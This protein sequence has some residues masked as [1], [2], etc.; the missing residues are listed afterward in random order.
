MFTVSCLRTCE[1]FSIILPV[2][3]ASNSK[4]T[5]VSPPFAVIFGLLL[6]AL[7]VRLTWLTALAVFVNSN[8]SLP[9]ESCNTPPPDKPEILGAFIVGV[10]TVG[11]VSVLFVRVLVLESNTTLPLAFGSTIW[12]SPVGSTTCKVVSCAFAVVPSNL[13]NPVAESL[14]VI[15]VLNA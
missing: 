5:L 6:V 4:P 12:L 7:L 2:P 10:L 14:R 15:L 8:T 9:E 11:L 3:F 1:L 13:I